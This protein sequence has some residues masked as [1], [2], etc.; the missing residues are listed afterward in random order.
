[1]ARATTPVTTTDADAAPLC[2]LVGATASGKKAVALELAQRLPF[3]LLSLDSMKV[4]RGMDRGTDKQAPARF[5]LTNLVEPT[6]RFSVGDYVRAASDAVAALRARGRLPLFVGGTG[7][8]LRALVRGLFE[9]PPIDPAVRQAVAERVERDG[10]PAA[11]AELSRLDPETAA[12]LHVHDRKRIVRALEVVAQ[13]GESL[14]SWQLRATRRPIAGRPLL[15]GI[16]WQRPALR[17]RIRVRIER[18]FAAGLVDEV[19]KLLATGQLGP[20]AALAIGY[21]EVIDYLRSGG[22]IADC[23]QQVQQQLQERV[24]SDT[25]T[26]MRRQENWFRQFPE[27]RWVDAPGRAATGRRPTEDELVARV[28]AEFERSLSEPAGA[29]HPDQ[30]PPAP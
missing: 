10:L 4:Y 15:V 16:R 20:V 5:A 22:T 17:E 2:F 23:Q 18:M 1:M 14:S 25:T 7:L 21:R 28:A 27:I 24:V 11:H 6:V 8:Y 12:R 26:F 19:A 29:I 13:T 3:E 30:A 9:V